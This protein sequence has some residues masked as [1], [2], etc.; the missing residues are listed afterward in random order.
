[1]ERK[2]VRKCWRGGERTWRDETRKEVGSVG[3]LERGHGRRKRGR[4]EEVL[5][6][7]RE[8]RE[9]GNEEGGRKCWR[10]GE[11]KGKEATR[12]DGGSVGGVE[13]GKGRRKRRRMEEAFGVK[14]RGMV[15]GRRNCRREQASEESSEGPSLHL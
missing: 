12:K 11:R 10:G 15:G 1:M 7:W 14:Q 6:G 9:G 5:E 2:E 3:G 13:R 4:M 8:E